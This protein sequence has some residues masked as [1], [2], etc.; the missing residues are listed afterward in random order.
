MNEQLKEEIVRILLDTI[1]ENVKLIRGKNT[2]YRIKNKFLGRTC[3]KEYSVRYFFF[4]I[5]IC[6]YNLWILLNIIE[7]GR[8]GL[9]TSKIPIKVDRLVHLIRKLTID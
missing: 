5:T 1:E 8:G 9:D 2:Q 7:R 6:I 3:S 4:L